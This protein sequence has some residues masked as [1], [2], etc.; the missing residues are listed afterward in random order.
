MAML[1]DKSQAI[2]AGQL[3]LGIGAVWSIWQIWKKRYNY[4]LVGKVSAVYIFPIKS[5]R[6]IK[7]PAAKFTKLG[8]QAC[9][10]R[11]REFVVLDEK[12]RD[13]TARQAPKMVLITPS[14]LN[15]SEL[16]LDA[17]GMETLKLSIPIEKTDETD[18]NSNTDTKGTLVSCNVWGDPM[19]GLDCGVEVA[20]WLAK[21]LEKP[22]IK[23]IYFHLNASPRI[24]KQYKL[25]RTIRKGDNSIYANVTAA[26]FLTDASLTD[27]NSKLEKPVSVHNFRPNIMIEGTNP[28]DEDTW[29]FVR[30]GET[31]LRWVQPCV[32]CIMTT[33][34]PETGIMDKIEPIK[35]LRKYRKVTDK[36][37]TKVAGDSP[38]M[39][40]YGA[41][42]Y[43]GYVRVGA[44]VY[45]ISK[46][47]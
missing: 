26:M 34:D 46:S 13:L 37:I 42:D 11:D 12:H 6:G 17:P 2:L 15:D 27:L 40:A 32:R 16:W 5:C 47:Q 1:G 30:I 39:G 38:V 28:F 23:M 22:N 8:P 19:V 35:T 18:K 25:W 45:A 21:F 43:E 29:Q 10:I 36:R 4:R 3:L 31:L 44:P 9:G 14:I 41:V 20:N 24:P 7:V 33:V